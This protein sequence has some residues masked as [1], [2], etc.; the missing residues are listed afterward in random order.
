[1]GIKKKRSTLESRVGEILEPAGFD[2]EAYKIPYFIEHMYTPDFSIGNLM[3]EVK[4]WFRPGDRQKYK[5]IRDS[6]NDINCTFVFVLQAPNKRVQKGAKS[7]MS[8][9]CDK[10]GIPWYS[11]HDLETLIADA[12]EA[13][14]IC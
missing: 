4:G 14:Q 1:M 2:Y 13:E 10:E 8:Q 7:T 3:V 11:E 5:A 6:M 12:V 9:W